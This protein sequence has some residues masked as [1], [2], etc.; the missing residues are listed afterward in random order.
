MSDDNCTCCPQH[1]PS[2]WSDE[3]KRLTDAVDR[4]THKPVHIVADGKV[5]ARI[6]NEV[7]GGKARS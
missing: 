7:G 5:I 2:A 1:R 3:L 6:A 4:L